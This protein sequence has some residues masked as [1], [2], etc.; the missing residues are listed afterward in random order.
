[1]TNDDGALLALEV[2]ARLAFAIAAVVL[3]LTPVLTVLNVDVILLRRGTLRAT[4]LLASAALAISAV[5]TVAAPWLALLHIEVIW[6]RRD[7]MPSAG[8]CHR[9]LRIDSDGKQQN[10]DVARVR[11]KSAME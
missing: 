11:R 4:K 3:F 9:Q 1:M 7:A 2:W 8:S 10:M 5:V 6:L